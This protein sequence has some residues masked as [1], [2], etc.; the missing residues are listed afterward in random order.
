ML[1]AAGWAVTTGGLATVGVTPTHPATGL[2]YV[3]VSGDALDPARWRAPSGARA[4]AA[5]HQAAASAP[6]FRAAGFV[7]KPSLE[8]ARAYLAGGAHLWNS[9]LFAWT[10]T[11]FAG[12]LVAAD[13]GLSGRIDAV[14]AARRRGDEAEA[15]SLYAGLEAVPVDTLVFERTRR[16]TV[17]QGRFT[18]S[19]LGSFADL[20]AAR[21]RTGGADPAG[22]VVDGEVIALDAGNS[23]VAAR[24]GRL[25]AVVGIDG[26]AVVDTGDALLVLP[27]DQTQRVKEV[28]A[29]LERAGRTDLL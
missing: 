5:R 9:G 15:T 27:L 17:V 3:E 19:D 23:F 8:V 6:A 18:W 7:E 24:G 13:P 14:V 20:H 1:A 11:A 4:D 29:R 12:E 2:G 28:V 10:A 16:L 21:R 22:N 25:V 26:L